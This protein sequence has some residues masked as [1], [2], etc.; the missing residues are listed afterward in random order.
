MGFKNAIKRVSIPAP[1]KINLFLAVTGKR[2]DGFHEL[3]SVLAKLDLADLVTIDRV[4]EENHLSCTCIGADQ[5]DGIHNLAEEAVLL[6]RKRTGIK[7][8]LHLTIDKKIPVEAGLGGGSSD[9]VATLLALNAM[10]ES[11]LKQNDLIELAA[12]IG[13]DCPSFLIP[14]LCVAE[15]RGERVRPVTAPLNKHMKGKSV[16]LFKP[17]LGF[18]TA[19]IFQA[20]GESEK[21]SPSSEVEQKLRTWESQ[22]LSTEKFLANDLELPVFEKHIYIPTLFRDIQES[23]S[24]IPRLSGSGSCCFCLGNERV[25]WSKV[26]NVI[27]KAWGEEVFL[28]R[29]QIV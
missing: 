21:F 3:I 9:A 29:A 13:S 23:F 17:S 25:P 27:R 1:A 2:L 10:M 5:L 22:N 20:L 28:T 14:G 8:G 18:S 4:G 12:Q 19:A 16:L 11:P 15:G 7:D 26:E 6:W 24:L